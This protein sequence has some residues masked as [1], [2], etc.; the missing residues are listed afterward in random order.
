MKTSKKMSRKQQILCLICAVIVIA[1]M[2][3]SKSQ[4]DDYEEDQF[5]DYDEFI[6]DD[7]TAPEQ[8]QKA[9]TQTASFNPS[10]PNNTNAMNNPTG[11]VDVYDQGLR[12][13]RGTYYLPQGW[14]L[15]HDIATDPSS[16]KYMKYRLD[17][18]GTQGEVIR[19]L[20]VKNYA[21]Y[22]GTFEQQ[23]RQDTNN[24]L[25]GVLD[26][27]S[28][29]NLT[30]S[31]ALRTYQV[32]RKLEGLAG[33]QGN[34]VVCR[35]AHISGTKNGKSYSG[36]VLIHNIIAPNMPNTGVFTATLVVS[37]TDI[38]PKTMEVSK[39]ISDNFQVNPAWEQ[40]IQ[41]I[42][43]SVLSSMNSQHQQRMA[44]NQAQFNA[45]QQR[46][47]ATRQAY[48]A[49]NRQWS[50]NFN[51]SGSYNTNPNNGYSTNDY[52]NDVM[53]ESTTFYDP[54][55]GNNV[56]LDGFQERTF[57]NGLGDFHRTDDAFFDPNSLQGD[58]KEVNP[59]TP[60]Y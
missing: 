33:S 35:E 5:L 32:T 23:W 8:M 29:G 14:K 26:Q 36:K 18:E 30:Q 57:T 37:P 50:Q 51:N 3:F 49:Q 2:A 4:E 21:P 47:Q 48:D 15:Y 1:S 53:N 12:M 17:F 16:G 45:H 27:F 56:Q 11:K 7:Y 25:R 10:Q 22:A 31:A 20:M 42:N 60:N 9:E 19:G 59:V 54:Y 41:Q 34:Q 43:Q 58:W 24:G 38:F 6:N 44:N 40:R 46:M 28:I 52:F 39:Q 55:T 13:S